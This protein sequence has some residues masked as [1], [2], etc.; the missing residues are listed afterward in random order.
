MNEAL[1]YTKLDDYLVQCRLCP[2]NCTIEPGRFGNCHARRNR[3]G[4]LS[5]EVYGKLAAVSLDPVEKKP[6]YHFFPGKEIL[7]IGTT[8]CNLHCIFC[9]NYTLSQCDNR[10]T[11]LIKN[12]T[13]EELAAHSLKKKNN[14]GV[15][16][17]YNE[18]TV[19][20]EFMIR[21]SEL[22]KMNGQ[23]TV[24]VSNGYINPAPLEELLKTI[25]AFNI[26]LKAFDE[27]F[28]KKYSKATLE[29]VKE[30]II[31]IA[32]SGKHLEITNLVIP[33]MNDDDDEFEE[34][35]DWISHETGKNTVLHLSRFFPRYELDQYPTPAETLFRLYDI[36]K[37]KLNFVYIGNLAT[38]IHSNTFCPNCRQLLIERTYYHTKL[39][40]IDPVGKCKK[41]GIQVIKYC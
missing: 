22:V 20:F 2:R 29:P 25:D 1:F 14:L 18:P 24:M 5:S 15:A 28:Y 26:D 39:K 33:T 16:F 7:S 11:V 17:T 38:E 37:S 41:C 12:M 19:N 34:M 35:C 36:A 32:A 21:T 9:Q 4:I 30:T 31:R 10:R 27:T 40:D 8:G 6:L 3:G 13:P 23:Y